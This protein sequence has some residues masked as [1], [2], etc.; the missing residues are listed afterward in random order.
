VLRPGDVGI[1]TAMDRLVDQMYFLVIH[2][3]LRNIV[4]YLIWSEYGKWLEGWSN[5]PLRFPSNCQFETD[6]G[7]HSAKIL[8]PGRRTKYLDDRKLH[9]HLQVHTYEML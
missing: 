2:E 8:C 5:R 6:M 4:I 1:T 9:T 3:I 7:N